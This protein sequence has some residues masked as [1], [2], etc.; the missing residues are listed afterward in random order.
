MER[1]QKVIAN[2]G[3][4]SRRKAEELIVEGKVKVNGIVVDQLGF[5]VDKKDVI[6]VEGNKIELDEKITYALNKP[7]NV[8]CTTC[9]DRKRICVTD[10]IEEEVR[11][12]PIGRLDYNSTGLIFLTNDGELTNSILQPKN[13]IP[14]TY[15]VTIDGIVSKDEICTLEKGVIID[16]YFKTGKAEIKITNKNFN[17]KTSSLKMTIYEGHNRQIRKMFELLGYNVLR[18]HRIQIANFELG[19]LKSGQYRKLKPYE[20]VKLKRYLDNI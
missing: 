19:N 13:K 12:Y 7:K 8:L 14:K 6:E 3:Y 15:E 18:L 1:I 10:L 17:K 9:D 4:C 5:K 16:G 2:S 11:I 20:I